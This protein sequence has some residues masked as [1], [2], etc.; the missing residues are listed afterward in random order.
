MGVRIREEPFPLVRVKRLG[1]FRR[2]PIPNPAASTK[3]SPSQQQTPPIRRS[4]TTYG[5]ISAI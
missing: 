2:Q 5:L 3:S 4:A 1:L